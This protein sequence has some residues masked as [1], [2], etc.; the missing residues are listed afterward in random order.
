MSD[1]VKPPDNEME[2][3]RYRHE[4]CRVLNKKTPVISSD[5]TA[6]DVATI[7]SDFNAL[8]AALRTAFE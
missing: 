5:S 7:V 4:I 6:A 8:L 2:T 1:F 3:E